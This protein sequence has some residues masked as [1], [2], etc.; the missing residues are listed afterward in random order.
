MKKG[1]HYSPES[2]RKLS[3]AIKKLWDKP[4]YR[5]RQIKVHTGYKQSEEQIQ[6]RIEKYRGEKHWAWKGDEVG[7]DALHDW[8]NKQLGKAEYCSIDRNHEAPLYYWANKSGQYLRDLNDWWSL[9][10]SCNKTDGVKIATRFI[11]GGISV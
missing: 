1:S 6:K 11:K 5:E 9:C 8:V 3:E 10:P 2:K 7:Y 4:G